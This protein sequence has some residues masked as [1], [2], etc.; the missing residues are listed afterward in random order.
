LTFRAAR[1]V[2]IASAAKWTLMTALSWIRRTGKKAGLG[3]AEEG[4]SR[5]FEEDEEAAVAE[6]M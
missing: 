6:Q 4:S 2:A 5:E 1:S 3:A